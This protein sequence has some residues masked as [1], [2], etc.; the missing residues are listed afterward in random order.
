MITQKTDAHVFECLRSCIHNESRN[1]GALWF[2]RFECSALVAQPFL[3]DIRS[4]YGSQAR[5]MELRC[6]WHPMGI[7]ANTRH[8]VDSVHFSSRRWAL[9]QCC[10]DCSACVQAQG[11]I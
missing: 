11:C 6:V 1:A 4:A 8:S 9:H 10:M 7:S 2:A 5:A 3:N